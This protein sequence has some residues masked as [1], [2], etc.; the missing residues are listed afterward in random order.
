M[1]NVYK[2]LCWYIL[3]F[4]LLSHFCVK[5]TKIGKIISKIAKNSSNET[6]C[7]QA[8]RLRTQWQSNMTRALAKNQQRQIMLGE[9]GS[10]PVSV[11]LTKSAAA[12]LQEKC[13]ENIKTQKEE[14]REAKMESVKKPSNKV[15]KEK[16]RLK[17]QSI[18]KAFKRK[19]KRSVDSDFESESSGEAEFI[20]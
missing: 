15:E 12:V 18:R 7:E 10:T 5:A 20:S 19:R 9:K 4:L 14:I 16:K 2:V 17:Q 8:K 1:K 13:S 3:I 11:V 6:V